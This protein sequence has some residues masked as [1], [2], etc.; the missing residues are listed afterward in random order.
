LGVVVH[1]STKA[2]FAVALCS[3]TV[4]G[5]ASAATK[6]VSAGPPLKKAPPGV[7]KDGDLNQ[8]FPSAI[9]I[10]AGDSVKWTIAG[11][12]VVTF[13]KKGEAP[14]QLAVPDASKPASGVNDAA[15]APFWFNGQGTPIVPAVV[16]LGTGSG[17]A[18]T[19]AA[20]VG[21][22]F[23]TGE[24]PKPFVVKFPK[25][26]SYTYFCTIHPGMKAKV[27]VVAKGK[28]VPSARADAARTKKQLAQ[29]LATLKKLDKTKVGAANTVVA[30][31][32]A[33]GGPVL[34][35]FSPNALTTKVNTPVSLQMTAGTTEIHTFTFAKDVKAAGKRAEK[36]LLAPLPGGGGPPTLAF[37]PKWVYPSDAPGSTVSYDGSN[38]GD[39]FLNSGVLD[40][41]SQTPFGQKFS[42]SFAKAGTYNFFC[43]IHPFMVGKIT[44]T[45]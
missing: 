19:G 3:L 16:G 6:V 32:D 40:G 12:H 2:A 26:G 37:S 11:F 30:G 22:G 4:P 14:P 42:V 36:E 43:A 27:T 41:S 17:K 15:G 10:H 20:A 24:K 5:A 7:P 45:Q 9:R 38:H 28:A 44:V 39:G 8:F 35:R 29:G 13:P 18:Y 34:F 23:P 21:S 25:A 33:K 31:P 1:R